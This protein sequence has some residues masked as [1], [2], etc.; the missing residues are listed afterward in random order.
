MTKYQ[1]TPE[2]RQ[3]IIEA[4]RDRESKLLGLAEMY[5]KNGDLDGQK[6]CIQ[7]WRKVHRFAEAL[8]LNQL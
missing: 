3:L 7:E 5:K 2:Q 6:D 1:L 8:Y 4:L